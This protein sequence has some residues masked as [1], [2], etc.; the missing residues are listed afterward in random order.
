ML[1]TNSEKEF[2]IHVKEERSQQSL[3]KLEYCKNNDREELVISSTVVEDDVI[4]QTRL[5]QPLPHIEVY[6]LVKDKDIAVV[7]KGQWPCAGSDQKLKKR[8]SDF[9]PGM[10]I[11]FYFRAPPIIFWDLSFMT[12]TT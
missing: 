8:L 2:L 11:F 5:V 3:E 9:I 6:H 10:Y 7:V 12:R 4:L 1:E